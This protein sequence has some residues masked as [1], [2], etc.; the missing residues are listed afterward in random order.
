SDG[1]QLTVQNLPPVVAP[2]QDKTVNQFDPVSFLAN[3]TDPGVQ[4]THLA[5]INWGDGTAT[6]SANVQESN[7][8]GTVTPVSSH[9]Y[10]LGGVYTAT[11]TVT[12]DAGASDSKTFRVIVNDV[13]PSLT[14]SGP[15]SVNEGSVYTLTMNSNG[16]AGITHWTI[17]W[18]DG[19]T[20]TLDGD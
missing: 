16:R 2:L 10:N 12:D 19:T 7:G 4:D 13:T 20:V 5:T 11:V 8:I 15:S 17:N 14:I 6:Q 9:A 1:M 18:G 3:F